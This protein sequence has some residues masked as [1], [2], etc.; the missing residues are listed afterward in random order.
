MN[1]IGL[2]N[3]SI[4]RLILETKGWSVSLIRRLRLV[5]EAI[6]T[7]K[8]IFSYCFIKHAA[9]HKPRCSPHVKRFQTEHFVRCIA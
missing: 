9:I 2:E 5:I 7:R 1:I 6:F 8:M 3:N 4:T